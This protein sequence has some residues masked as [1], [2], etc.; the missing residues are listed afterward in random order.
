MLE[1]IGYGKNGRKADAETIG[2]FLYRIPEY[3]EAL[4]SY[5]PQDNRAI[6]AKLDELLADDSALAKRFHEKRKGKLASGPKK[7][8]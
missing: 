7:I 3:Q 5:K 1:D 6:L 4:E 2:D 8:K